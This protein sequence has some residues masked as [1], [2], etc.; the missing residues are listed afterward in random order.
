MA[1]QRK[2]PLFNAGAAV[3]DSFR[4]LHAPAERI[5]DI[6]GLKQGQIVLD[7]ACGSGRTAMFASKTVGNSGK[8]FGID[9]ADKLLEVAEAKAIGNNLRNIEYRVG[10]AHK[11]DFQNEYFDVVLCASSLFLFDDIKAALQESFRVLKPG[12]T[13]VC[14]VFGNGIFEPVV[15]LINERLDQFQDK[16][17][18]SPVSAVTDTHEKCREIFSLS[19]L[20]DVEIITE[21]L[22]FT[23]ENAE[24]CWR[25][26][27]NSLIVRPRLAMLE[28]YEYRTVK[29]EVQ[30][31]LEAILTPLGILVEVP[32]IFC[33][34]NK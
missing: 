33:T 21:Q 9:I 6:A 15:S 34:V 18:P 13:F 20:T 1:E 7:L 3:Y 27:A 30:K 12:G 8:V 24:D 10:N 31:E 19:G 11:L 23:V 32:V 2:E 25:Q 14:S 4:F 26:V 17:L 29:E 16:I 22:P 5:T 28:K